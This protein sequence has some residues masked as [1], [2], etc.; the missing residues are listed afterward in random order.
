MYD[1]VRKL[2]LYNPVG[3]HYPSKEKKRL[4]FLYQLYSTLLV[5]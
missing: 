2:Q 4:G 5:Y 1:L 3:L